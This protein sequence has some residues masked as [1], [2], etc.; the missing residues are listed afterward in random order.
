MSEIENKIIAELV[1]YGITNK[2]EQA[3]FL[4][5]C[6]HE[7][8]NFTVLSEAIKYRFIRAKQIWPSRTAIIEAKQK[9]LNAKNDD[10]CPQ[11][12]LFNTMYNGRMGNRPNSNDGFDF[13]GGGYIQLTGR[14][15]YQAFCVWLNKPGCTIDTLDI[16][17]NWLRMKQDGAILSAIWFWI[18][19]NI[20]SLAIADDVAAITKKINGGIH[21]LENRKKLLVKYK[22]A[23]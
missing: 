14:E 23:L 19:R 4:A 11:P 20:K 22:A 13:R 16:V 6:A 7:S 9:E 10:Y 17:A 15:N 18:T 3:H 21:G 5:Q 12:W 1:K 8:A 2:L